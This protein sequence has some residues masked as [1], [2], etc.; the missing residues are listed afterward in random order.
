MRETKINL[1][2]DNKKDLIWCGL[3]DIMVLD[4]V[5]WRNMIHVADPK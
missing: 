5:E 3:T 2:G 1:G 4:R